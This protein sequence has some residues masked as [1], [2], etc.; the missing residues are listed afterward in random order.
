VPDPTPA[1]L[2][3]RAI[4]LRPL[5]IADQAAAEERSNY[6]PE[7]HERFQEAG[8]YRMFVPKRYGGLEVDVPTFMR[9]AVEIARGCPSTAWCLA[10]ASN[11]ALM[12]GSWFPE[13][14]QDEVFGDGRFICA[15]VASPLSEVATP[16]DGEWELR[17]RVAFCSGIPYSTWFMGQALTPPPEPGGPPGPLM[18]YVAPRGV[19]RQLDDWGDILGLRGSGSQTI[20]FDGGRIPAHYVLENT[21]MVDIDVSQGTPGYALHENPMYAG[22]ALSIFTM[23]LGAVCVGAAYNALDEY[24][25]HLN[26]R[27]T[28]LPPFTPRRTDPD[29]QRIYGASLAKTATAEAALRSAADEYM[30]LCR[31]SVDG[32]P[33]FTWEDDVRLGCICR[34]V[35]VQTWET[36]QADLVRTIGASL[37]RPGQ[38]I[39]RIFRDLAVANAHRNTSLRDWQFRELAMANLGIPRELP[40]GPLPSRPGL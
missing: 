14:T 22:R 17:G 31:R 10:L 32:G 6:S 24:K 33:A 25:E 9:V 19:W 3:E 20:V 27:S 8:F 38:R 1:E 15:S 11:H 26:T 35:M 23:C 5:L 28:L 4:E 18:L 12:V 13:Q 39:E 16:A 40:G 2:I 7:M 29:F 36:V 21:F 37:M 30:E 34:E